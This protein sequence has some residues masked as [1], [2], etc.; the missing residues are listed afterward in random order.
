MKIEGRNAI[1]EL[2]KT[3]NDIDKVMVDKTLNDNASLRLISAL[4]NRGVK[5][6]YV[7]KHVLAKESISTRHQGFVAY[8]S[9][10]DYA[11]FEEELDKI[12]DKDDGLVVVL[13]EVVDPHNL[14]SII[15]V[16]ECAG[17]DLLVIG[18]NRCASV[19]DTVIRISQGAAEHLKV[20][21]VTNVN[22]AIDQLK[23]AGFWVSGAELG[24]EDLFGADLTGKTV[25]V[26][27]GEDSG[28]KKLTKQK[29]DRIITIPMKGQVNSLNASV[30]CGIVIYEAVRQR[31]KK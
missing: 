9:E 4:R 21:R 18:K 27:G 19:N 2:L 22:K 28:I 17:A 8:V 1:N 16:L 26:I 23:E 20:A 31:L 25:V 13:E 5:I 7:D 29:C 6:Q 30:A 15:R 24:G 12:K 11:D 14:G 3:E 10:Y